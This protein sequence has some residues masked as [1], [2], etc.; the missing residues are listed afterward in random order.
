MLC[1]SLESLANWRTSVWSGITAELDRVVWLVVHPGLAERWILTAFVIVA[2]WSRWL[3]TRREGGRAGQERPIRYARWHF[4]VCCRL[5]ATT[6]T[7]PMTGPSF[8]LGLVWDGLWYRPS[9][10]LGRPSVCAASVTGRRL[11]T[12]ST[13]CRVS[14]ISGMWGHSA[15]TLCTVLAGCSL[16]PHQKTISYCGKAKFMIRISENLTVG[17]CQK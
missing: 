17:L 14:P 1:A 6:L 13:S 9:Y 11:P 2:V 10:F 12:C 3:P 15:S 8:S 5:Y 7:F 16:S 4:L